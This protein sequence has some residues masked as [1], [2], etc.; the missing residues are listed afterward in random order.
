MEDSESSGTLIK[1]T[2]LLGSRVKHNK[3]IQ[4]LGLCGVCGDSYDLPQ[5]RDNEMGGIYGNG[6]IT[7]TYTENQIVNIEVELTAY[8]QGFFEFRVCP[9]NSRSLPASQTCLDRHVLKQEGGGEK[10]YPPS[11]K[12]Q[13]HYWLNYRLPKG[14]TCEL[15]VLQWRYFAG[16]SWG[17]CDNGTESIGCGAQVFNH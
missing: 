13:G 12:Q 8:H 15:C 4:I 9:L 16:N 17:R 5:P 11:P 14:V 2:Q 6:I 10:F 7:E 3:D 1:V